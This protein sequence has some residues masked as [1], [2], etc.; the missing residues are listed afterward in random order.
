[1]INKLLGI[2]MIMIIVFANTKAFAQTVS[3][4][5]VDNSTKEP[6]AGATIRVVGT[7]DRDNF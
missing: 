2:T 6:L 4:K 1:M 7:P 3:G 5:I